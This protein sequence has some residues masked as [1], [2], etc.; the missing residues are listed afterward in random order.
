MSAHPEVK[1]IEEVLKQSPQYQSAASS[2]N[3]EAYRKFGLE[4]RKCEEMRD[5]YLARAKDLIEGLDL[6]M[7]AV[8][9]A[10]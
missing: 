8:K 1:S 2:K 3:N 4:L 10:H 6:R 5:N 9:G 7:T